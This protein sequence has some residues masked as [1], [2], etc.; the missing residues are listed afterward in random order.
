M[1]NSLSALPTAPYKIMTYLATSKDSEAE[2][3]WKIIK[4]K[5]YIINFYSINRIFM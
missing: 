2:N 4:R 1:Y 5:Q 3:F